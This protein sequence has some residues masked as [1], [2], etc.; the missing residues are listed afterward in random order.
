MHA[1][2]HIPTRCSA[3]KHFDIMTDKKNE[4]IDT[5]LNLICE[6]KEKKI[7]ATKFVDI[8]GEKIASKFESEIFADEMESKGL[9]YRIDELC[10]VKELGLEIYEYG[11][12]KKYLKDKKEREKKSELAQKEK[13]GLELRKSK[14][15]LELAEKMLKEYPKTKWIARIGF[16]I[17]I[18]LAVLQLI[19]WLTQP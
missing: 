15:D 5:N 4:L 16:I 9:I 18:A 13:D 3:F 6:T 12:W 7:F 19:K 1:T 10:I 17:G 2:F 8:E 14:V 11:G